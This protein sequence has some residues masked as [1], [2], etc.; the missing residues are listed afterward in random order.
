MDPL[1]LLAYEAE[2]AQPLIEMKTNQ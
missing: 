2:Q 1:A